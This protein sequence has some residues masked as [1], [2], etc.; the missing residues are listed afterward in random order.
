MISANQSDCIITVYLNYAILKYVFMTLAH[1]SPHNIQYLSRKLA[2]R[3]FHNPFWDI[4]VSAYSQLFPKLKPSD[5]KS[6]I[7]HS[8]LLFIELTINFQKIE[9]KS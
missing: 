4:S 5:K 2:K 7:M 6:L 1:D 9:S 8:L 3:A